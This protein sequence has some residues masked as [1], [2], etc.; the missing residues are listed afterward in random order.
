LDLNHPDINIYNHL[1]YKK[2][3]G[4]IQ[5]TNPQK[6][7]LQTE[8]HKAY[9]SHSHSTSRYENTIYKYLNSYLTILTFN[10]FLCIIDFTEQHVSLSCD[11]PVVLVKFIKLIA[12]AR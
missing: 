7:A 5:E 3:G 2:G 12:D 9:A 10:L 6:Q 4:G 1:L 11:I 8:I